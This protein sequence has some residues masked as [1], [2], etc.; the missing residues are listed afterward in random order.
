MASVELMGGVRLIKVEWAQHKLTEAVLHVQEED[1]FM[2]H[3]ADEA[4]TAYYKQK[5]DEAETRTSYFPRLQIWQ[6]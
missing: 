3:V 6:K 2:S 1:K 4:E 5:A